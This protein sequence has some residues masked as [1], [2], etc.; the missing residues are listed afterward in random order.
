MDEIFFQV[1]ATAKPNG[2]KSMSDG[3]YDLSFRTQELGPAD[4]AAMSIIRG[5]FG[6]LAFVTKD[7]PLT[8]SDLTGIEAP[9]FVPDLGAGQKSPSVRLRNVLY[10]LWEQGGATEKLGDF[11]AY[12]LVRMNRIIDHIKEKLT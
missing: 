9:D 12:Y 6:Q 4:V 10:K 8:G 7:T 2:I 3:G 11:D 1:P 5:K